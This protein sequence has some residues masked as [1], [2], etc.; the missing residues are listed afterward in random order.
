MLATWL[1]GALGAASNKIATLCGDKGKVV[2]TSIFVFVIAERVTFLRFSPKLKARYDYGM[3]IFI[4]TFC[5]I[6]LSDM[7]VCIFICPVWIGEDLHNKIAGNIERVADFLEG[8][9]DE[10][11]N[12]SENTEVG[13]DK[14]FLERYKGVLSSKSS[15]ETMTPYEFRSRIQESCTTISLESG[16]AL[17]ESS[18]II[19]K[20]SKSSTPKSHI[21]NA[22]NAAESLKSIL[23]TNPWE[24]ADHFEIIPASTVASLLIDIVICVEQICEAVDELASLANFVPS[25]LLHRGTVQPVSDTDSSVH[26]VTVSE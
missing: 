20:M 4:L 6:S 5:L 21:L 13:N 10:Y 23:R 15:E 24:G 18:L 1:A 3:I 17:R 2:M 14:Q 22:K 8:F 26:I 25:E 7:T 19:K 12:N 9:G 16:K 11:F